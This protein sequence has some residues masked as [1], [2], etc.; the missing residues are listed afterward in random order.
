MLD[1]M[2]R[3]PSLIL[4]AAAVLGAAVPERP[5]IVYVMADDMGYGDLGVQG[6]PYIRTPNI[7]RLAREG[8][9][10]TDFYAQPFC[11]PSRAALMT[12]TYPARNSLAF[13]HLPHAKTGLH[14]N[15]ITIAEILKDRGYATAIIGKWHLGDA[16]EFLPMRHGFDYWYGLPYSNDMWPYHPK[17]I[18]RPDE[19]ECMKAS[20]QR[21]RYTGYAQSDQTYPLDWFPKLPLMR[22]AEVIALNP[23][24]EKLTGD[25]T[26]EAIGFIREHKD[27]PFFVYLAHSMP[28]VPLFRSR[29]FEDGSMRGRYGDVVAELDANVGKLMEAL[30]EMG[31]DEKTL[32]VFTS[33]NGPWVEYGF[34]AG[35]AGPLRGSKG[36]NYEGGVRVPFMARFPGQIPAGLVSSGIA[37]NIDIL[38]TLAGLAGGEAPRDRTIDGKDIWPVLSKPDAES[39]RDTFFYFVGGMAYKA[40]DGPPKNDPRLAAV[41]QGPW[42]LHVETV[43]AQ[44]KVEPRELYNLHEDVGERLDYAGKQPEVTER[45]R[46]AAQRFIDDLKRDTRPHGTLSDAGG[47]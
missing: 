19:D 31:L 44:S 29:P 47:R 38:P 4:C 26:D 24:Q 23:Q 11:G 22:N 21:A 12:G 8:V 32:V 45:L 9:R 10:L 17:I 5:N 30:R 39:P 6:H 1:R 13:N 33:D 40:A 20:R 42:K 3:L 25:Y 7:D 41:R 15:E 16:P 18:E 43:G 14:P 27:Q 35:S 2:L 46:K 28:H 36:T 34:D 37:A